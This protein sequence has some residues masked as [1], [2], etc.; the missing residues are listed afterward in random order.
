MLYAQ[1][2]C[3]MSMQIKTNLLQDDIVEN[4]LIEIQKTTEM[5]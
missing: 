4:L 2:V 5:N 1:A 3:I